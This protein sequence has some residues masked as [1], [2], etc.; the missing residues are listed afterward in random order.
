MNR[1]VERLLMASYADDPLLLTADERLCEI[2]RIF[3]AAILRLRTRP[4]LPADPDAQADLKDP[5]ESVADSLEVPG[6]SV[7]SDRRVH[8]F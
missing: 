2:A 8:G 7:L 3:A 6:E 4:A 5:P 1:T